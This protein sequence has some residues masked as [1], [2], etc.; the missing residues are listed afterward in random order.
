M[1]AIHLLGQ[2]DQ[3]AM[4]EGEQPACSSQPPFIVILSRKKKSH[5][6]VLTSSSRC[7][8]SPCL[9]PGMRHPSRRGQDFLRS[10]WGDISAL[11]SE[12]ST[13]RKLTSIHICDNC[14][15]SCVF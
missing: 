8:P 3:A 7:K 2:N 6:L 15:K 4:A 1:P 11:L 5:V 14:H 10:L 9:M 12:V 13:R